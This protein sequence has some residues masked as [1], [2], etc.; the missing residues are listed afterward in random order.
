M[1]LLDKTYRKEPIPG[2]LSIVSARV[3]ARSSSML[4]LKN[5]PFTP[6]E[7]DYILSAFDLMDPERVYSTCPFKDVLEK[8]PGAQGFA[9][10]YDYRKLLDAYVL[11]DKLMNEWANN[12]ITI[13]SK[14]LWP[15]NAW[16]REGK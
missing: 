4:A 8:Y 1:I 15:D 13:V 2:L 9:E 14:E 11:D 10:L 12:V 6:H 5:P 3:R 7:R 16:W